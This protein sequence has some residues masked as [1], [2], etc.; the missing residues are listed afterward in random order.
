LFKGHKPQKPE[1]GSPTEDEE[2]GDDEEFK[3]FVEKWQRDPYLH[4][5]YDNPNDHQCEGVGRET[6]EDA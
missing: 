1:G 5:V 6:N 4:S 3:F 2:T